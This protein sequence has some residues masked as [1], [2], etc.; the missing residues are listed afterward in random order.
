MNLRDRLVRAPRAQPLDL[1]GR[2]YVVTGIAAGSIGEST[3]ATLAAWGAR[4]IVS[5]RRDTAA[6]VARLRDGL[7]N[8]QC[9]D[10]IAGHPLDLCETA[11]VA[12]FADAVRTLCDGRLDGLV[13][14]AGIH[15]DLLSEWQ[16]PQCSADGVEIHW[17]TNYVGTLQLTHALLP[18]L[19]ATA[20]THGEA[21]VVNVVSMLHARGRNADL[22]TPVRPYNSWNAYGNSK[23][24]LVHASFELQRRHGHEGVQ[25]YALHPGAVYSNIAAH[26]LAGHALIGRLRRALAPIERFFLLTPDEGAQTSLHCATA[27]GLAGGRYFRDLRA[28]APSAE[29]LDADVAR[30]L[31]DA[32]LVNTPARPY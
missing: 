1:R 2:R 12:A 21:R 6:A 4:V 13:N 20:A 17:R 9:A 28:V 11:S 5:T 23:L 15:L 27:P 7:R 10:D 8:R 32:S 25:A 3:A 16:R 24:A 30:R 14:N 18:T 31:W 29:A 19:R 26:G 22:F